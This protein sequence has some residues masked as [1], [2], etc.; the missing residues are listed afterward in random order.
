MDTTRIVVE[1]FGEHATIN[2]RSQTEA[3]AANE[4][5][6]AERQ[7]WVRSA[8]D[9][10]VAGISVN[11]IF[12][13]MTVAGIEPVRQLLVVCAVAGWSIAEAREAFDRREI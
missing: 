1:G 7:D 11:T 9:G 10:F 12:A 3:L 6:M 8:F 4:A 13:Q 5:I 2:G